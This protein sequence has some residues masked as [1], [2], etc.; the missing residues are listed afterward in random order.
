M[1]PTTFTPFT[2][3]FGGVLIGVAAVLMMATTGRIAGVSGF[4]S[5]LLPPYEDDEVLSRLAFVAGLV[6]APLL[7]TVVSGAKVAHVVSSNLPLLAIAG[8]LV[9]A[10]AVVGGGCTS[11]HG[12]CGMARLSRRSIAATCMFMATAIVTVFVTRHLVGG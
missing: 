11:G 7:Y 2:S 1:E 12:V 6:L 8:L 10:G 9:G 5:R 3:L 4:V